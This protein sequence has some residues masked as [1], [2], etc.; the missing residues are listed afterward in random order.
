MTRR[1][2]SGFTLV[3]LL[4]SITIMAVLIPALGLGLLTVLKTM[5]STQTQYS[6]AHDIQYSALNF[7]SDAAS[8][9]TVNPTDSGN[10]CATA[11]TVQVNF[12]WTAASGV[13]YKADYSLVGTTLHR[14]LCSKPVSGSYAMVVDQSLA[15]SVTT[16]AATCDGV[17]CA[18]GAQPAAVKLQATAD[19]NAFSLS[20]TRRS[21]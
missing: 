15:S 16:V 2:E 14:L 11:G 7:Q 21:S 5:N 12:T 6:D 13:A 17:T 9:L 20:A 19:G 10:A 8:A 4:I 3:E 1:D 18:S